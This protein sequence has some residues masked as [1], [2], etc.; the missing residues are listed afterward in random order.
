MDYS[1]I[2]AKACGVK[3]VVL[4]HT[5]N[6]QHYFIGEKKDVE[7]LNPGTWSIFFEDVECEKEI[8]YQNCVWI[9]GQDRKSYLY[10]WDHK[11]IR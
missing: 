2:S 6:V 8:R 7:Y 9:H 4:G 10:N 3:R 1:P 11:T 5:H